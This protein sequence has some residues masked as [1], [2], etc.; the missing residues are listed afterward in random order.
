[1]DW[2]DAFLQVAWFMGID[3]LAPSADGCATAKAAKKQGEH[4]NSK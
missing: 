2:R 1:M 3:T 4:A